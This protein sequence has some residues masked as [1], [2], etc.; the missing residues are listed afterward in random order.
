[1][2]FPSTETVDMWNSGEAGSVGA[3]MDW[4]EFSPDLRAGVLVNI[5][6]DHSVHYR[7][8]AMTT[9]AEV[10]DVVVSTRVGEAQR[11]LTLGEKGQVRMLFNAMKAAGGTLPQQPSAVTS[12]I[13]VTAPEA[14]L[15]ASSAN[16]VALNGTVTRVGNKVARRITVAE[17]R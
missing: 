4:A 1:M 11:T 7:R 8:F 15:T 13:V 10:E 17:E 9:D 5:G 6:V 3:I 16:A 2:A 12:P 14:E